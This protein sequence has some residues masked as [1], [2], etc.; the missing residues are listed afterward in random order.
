MKKS[1]IRFS[2]SL[3]LLLGVTALSGQSIQIVSP[4][5]TTPTTP[6][7]ICQCDTL[8]IQRPQQL[9]YFL[10]G[11]FNPTTTFHY[12]LG[13]DSLDLVR[14]EKVVVPAQPLPVD[15]FGPGTKKAFLAVPCNAPL[16]PAIF[17]IRNSNGSISDTVHYIINRSPNKP[18]IKNII[19]GFPNAYTTGVDDWG[20]CQGDSITLVVEQQAGAS[21]QWLQGGVPIPGETDTAYKAFTAGSYAVRVDLGACSRDSK[22]TIIN[23]IIVPTLVTNKSVPPAVRQIDN[24]NP[25]GI[26][27]DSIRFCLGNTAVLEAN[28]PPLGSGLT[29]SFQWLT[30]SVDAF[31]VTHYYKTDTADT[32]QSLTVDTTGRY[33][34][35]IND[36]MCSDTSQPYY[37]YADT[38]PRTR[39]ASENYDG[40]QIGPRMIIQDICMTDSVRLSSNNTPPGWTYQ[41][42]RLNTSSML[43]ESLPN[44]ANPGFQGG[45]TSSIVIDPTV[46]PTQPLSFYRLR[47][48][49]V[50]SFT[51]ATVCE[52]FSAQVRVRYLAPYTLDYTPQPWVTSV[53]NDSVSLCARDS[54]QLVAPSTPGQL[55]TNGLNYSYQWLTDSIGPLGGVFKKAIP[56][57]TNRTYYTNVSGKYYIALD[58]GICIDTSTFFSVFVDSIPSTTISD[59]LSTGNGRLLCTNDS[60]LLKADTIVLPGW[61]YQ[62]QQYQASTGTWV[63]LPNDTLPATIVDISNR[64]PGEDTAYFRVSVSYLNQ[65]NL[66]ACSFISD[67]LFVVFFDPPV[68]N[69]FPGD[70]LGLCAGDS[71]MVNAQ[72]NSLSY[73]WSPTG[74]VSPNIT[75]SQTGTYTVTG[76]GV[77][78]CTT[79]RTL[80]VYPIVTVANAG[81]DVTTTS[82]TDVQLSGSGGTGY[83]WYANKPIAWS[84]FLSRNV[85]VSYTLPD[86]VKSDTITI[87]LEVTN[88]AGCL[89]TDSL[90]LIVT[91][92]E[93]P[94]ISRLEEAYNLFTPNND[95]MNDTW[96]ISSIVRD[97]TVCRIDIL[98]RWGS[99]VFNQEEFNGVWDG[100][101]NG[102]Q[103]L[104]DGTYYY[105]LSCDGELILKNAVTLIRNK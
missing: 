92:E 94:G 68:V 44:A 59:T 88:T 91:S 56:G 52:T 57:A 5:N 51:G 17:F 96:D 60:V 62:W 95:G 24:P 21:Y 32:L 67:S 20:F 85:T 99:V 66:P 80:T 28:A 10:G 90:T 55:V 69:L 105:I 16:G 50:T 37:V 82:G 48:R 4:L 63:T 46:L 103:E 100:R 40:A 47:T 9:Q 42:Q 71:I 1:F 8:G 58:D 7:S 13:T 83:R 45:T 93:D 61:R 41:W 98:N 2:A 54:V 12:V 18:I 11:T 33:Y 101:N 34:V 84:D 25:N 86:G 65:F 75:I 39:I 78:G 27:L 43:W 102:G 74:T 14:L 35:V 30:D 72:G 6:A 70:S 104:P 36:G 3:V 31:N 89:D 23:D 81:P 15:T 64:E 87:Y 22:D 49:T 97:Y 79:T 77:N 73:L 38:L 26:P 19:G 76:T 29:F 53:G